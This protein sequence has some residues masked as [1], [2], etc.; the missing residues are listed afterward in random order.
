[1]ASTG[2]NITTRTHIVAG[3]QRAAERRSNPDG[4][5]AVGLT[6]GVASG[7][8]LALE[9]FA[10]LGAQTISSDAIVHRLYERAEI[11]MALHARFGAEVIGARG[12]VDRA[13]LGRLVMGNEKELLALESLVHP[14]VAMDIQDFL[15]GG[16]PGDVSVCEVPLLF[17][18]GLQGRF[19]LVATL[20]APRELR[21]KRASSRVGAEAFDFL[22]ARL[23]GEEARVAGADFA[24]T[25]DGTVDD[26]A[27]F[28]SKVYAAAKQVASGELWR[29]L[30]GE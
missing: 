20:E 28:V 15:T 9:M 21:R 3:T 24:Y 6:G 16:A 7:K 2:T 25:N 22:D 30:G 8:S 19:D 5:A 29:V 26:L 12:K 14:R 4:R 1:M 23:A 10:A 17:E 18:S 11:Q 27:G 13:A